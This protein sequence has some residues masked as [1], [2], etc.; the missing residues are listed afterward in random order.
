MTTVTDSLPK[1]PACDHEPK[2]YTGPSYEEALEMRRTFINPGVFTLYKEPLMLV[3]GKMQYLWDHTGKR[4][5]D[6]F[7][8]ICT[9]SVGHCHPEVVAATAAQNETAQHIPT[10]YLHPAIGEYAKLL[11]STLPEPLRRVYFVNS[12]SEANDLALLMARL[13]TGNHDVIALRNCY[14]GGNAVGM[15]LTSH[16]T[17]KY[18]VPG[19]AGVHHAKA[20]YPYR[21]PW[22]HDDPEAGRKYAA[23]VREI[24]LYATPGRVAAF[25]AES[26][27]GVGGAVEFPAGYLEDAYAHVRAAGGVCIA[28]EV[29]SGFGRTGS[30]FWGFETQGVVP[31]IVVMAKSIANG[32]PLAAVVTTDEIAGKMTERTHFNTFAGNPPAM[33]QGLKVL[34]IMLRDDTQGLCRRIGG[35]I[36]AG[37]RGLQNKHAVIGEV[38]GRGLMLGVE[39]VKDRETKEPA[40]AECATILEKAREMGLMLGKGGLF[41]NTLRIKPPMC[42]TEEDADFLVEVI[43]VACG[44]I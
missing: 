17:W 40:S 27:Q 35:R 21:G 30:H 44:E 42:L 5:L 38:R 11:T 25:I 22:G 15:G 24:L 20:P 37:L 28:D 23:D 4:Y 9:V 6:A 16:H 12:G 14:H 29:Q 10:I 36:I 32:Y 19:A 31:D 1:L 7:G 33:V 26:I 41:G 2:P 39:L 3:E 13:H 34:E 8:G 43:D 18:N